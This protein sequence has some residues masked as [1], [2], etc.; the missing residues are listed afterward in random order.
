[1]A[2]DPK[3]E[4]LINSLSMV[5]FLLKDKRMS[6]ISSSPNGL[7]ESNLFIFIQAI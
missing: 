3:L 2:K 5:S 4:D 1:L 6:L 7:I